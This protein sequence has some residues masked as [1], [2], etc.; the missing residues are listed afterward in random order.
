MNILLPFFLTFSS[1]SFSQTI[2]WEN[3]YGGKSLEDVYSM[4]QIETGEFLF[5]GASSSNDSLISNYGGS[6]A[7]LIKTDESGEMLW[8]KN[9]GGSDLDRFNAIKST[10]SGFILSGITASPDNDVSGHLGEIDY[11]LV[12]VSDDGNLEWERTLG[13]MFNDFCEDVTVANDGGFMI[14]GHAERTN[15]AQGDT[16]G[17]IDILIY[18]VSPSGEIEWQKTYDKSFF[19]RLAK[20]IPTSDGGFLIG[21][22][23]YSEEEQNNFWVLKIDAFGEMMWEKNYGGSDADV[24]YDLAVTSGGYFLGGTSKSTDGDASSLSFGLNDYWVLKI[25]EIGNVIWEQKYGHEYYDALKTLISTA[26]GGA[27]LCGTSDGKDKFE[28]TDFWAVKVDE[29]GTVEWSKNYGLP[30][31]DFFEA[32]IQSQDGGFVLGGTGQISQVNFDVNTDFLIYKICDDNVISCRPNAVSF[33][34][35]I[36]TISEVQLS[37]NPTS[38]KLF[39]QFEN[40][41]SEVL[42]LSVYDANSK[43]LNQSK[44]TSNVGVN[45]HEIDL[46]AYANGVYYLELESDQ[47]RIVSKVIKQD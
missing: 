14:G 30:N 29:N 19:D 4:I 11:W 45:N 18:K 12:K 35:R 31:G 33:P 46:S 1:I 16:F 17:D 21:G 34:G 43:L 26:D 5:A 37:P 27:F 3:H 40:E 6:D 44:I 24:L 7:W 25:D 36:E 39:I 10:E 20:I 28:S 41:I 47:N 9:Y 15:A 32:A 23:S 42:R 38:A 2:Q 22:T 13:G 8:Q